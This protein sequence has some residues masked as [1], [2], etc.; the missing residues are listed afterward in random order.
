[1]LSS[2]GEQN[3][4][5]AKNETIA[6]EFLMLT[7]AKMQ[8]VGLVIIDSQG[9]AIVHFSICPF[10]KCAGMNWELL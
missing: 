2:P 6:T 8:F 9:Q 5:N 1:M 10:L 7:A 4:T 3:G